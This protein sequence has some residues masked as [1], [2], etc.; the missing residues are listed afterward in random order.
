MTMQ[1]TSWK[2]KKQLYTTK[3]EDLKK[4]R[5]DLIQQPK[6]CVCYTF[7][8]IYFV[9]WN[10]STW[11]T[12]TCFLFHFKGFFRSGDKQT[13]TSQIFRYH[14]ACYEMLKHNDLDKFW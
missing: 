3:Q 8:L 14:D 11:E 9:S 4:R 5:H 13:L 7:L 12:R 6:G 10:D 2:K 1:P